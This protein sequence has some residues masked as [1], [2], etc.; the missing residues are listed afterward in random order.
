MILQ[1]IGKRDAAG[2]AKN[3]NGYRAMWSAKGEAAVRTVVATIRLA[4][5]V[6]TFPPCS[7]R[8]A[9]DLN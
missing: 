7:E 3:T 9:P 2:D 5:G 4:V 6:P 8:S 1:C